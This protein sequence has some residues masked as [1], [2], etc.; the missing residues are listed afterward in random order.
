MIRKR[1]PSPLLGNL[2]L[3]SEDSNGNDAL[4]PVSDALQTNSFSDAFN[5][6]HLTGPSS[7]LQA[8][9]ITGPDSLLDSDELHLTPGDSG[10]SLNQ[11]S[12]D[13][14]PLGGSPSLSSVTGNLGNGSGVIGVRRGIVDLDPSE[15]KSNVPDVATQ[16]DQ[17]EGSLPL[18]A[19]PIG[20]TGFGGR[21]RG[22]RVNRMV[23]IINNIVRN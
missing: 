4:S 23:C 18:A 20:F 17:T 19:D 11:L 13:G 14:S 10:T 3:T 2:H 5:K 22:M 8:H 6:G 15:L 1:L 21:L 12:A 7:F 16:G 9:Q